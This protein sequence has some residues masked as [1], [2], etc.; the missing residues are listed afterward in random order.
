MSSPVAVKSPKPE[1]RVH[2]HVLLIAAAVLFSTGGAVIKFTSL[3]S[4]QVASFRAAIAAVFLC[5]VLPAARR[6]W[7]LSI[8][9]AATAYAV[10]LILFVLATRATTAANAIFLQS[11]APLYLLFLGPMVLR[12]P[13]RKANI[14]FA[15]AV[16]IG[17]VFLLTGSPSSLATAPNPS[18]GNL[19]AAASGL[20]WAVTV[21]GLRWIAR[22]GT[23][24]RTIATVTVGNLVA[25]VATLPMAFPITTS[26]MADI[27]AVFYLGIAQIG[28]A[29][30]CFAR[31]IRNV[32]AFEATTILLLEPVLNPIWT[33]LL[34][35]EFPGVASLAGGGVI[36]SATLFNAWHEARG[37]K[38]I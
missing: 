10:T 37:A 18:L 22:S 26:S 23:E 4:W 21:T 11:T 3:T 13:L 33:W 31:A 9:P 35:G 29:Y 32:S 14:A 15:A 24:N 28:L 20:T 5:V 19:L 6:N 8:L 30:L 2:N 34:H 16:A 36:L 27:A 17:M 38:T 12:E 7:S 25:C 1:T